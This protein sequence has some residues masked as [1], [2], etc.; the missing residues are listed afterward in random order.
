MFYFENPAHRQKLLELGIL[1]PSEQE[2]TPSELVARMLVSTDFEEVLY[3]IKQDFAQP[4]S[5]YSMLESQLAMTV[6]QANQVESLDD[7]HEC[8]A[9]LQKLLKLPLRIDEITITMQD[10][11]TELRAKIP[12]RISQ[13]TLRHLNDIERFLGQL[14]A[15]TEQNREILSVGLAQL[16]VILGAKQTKLM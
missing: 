3:I 7:L 10:F 15:L 1:V 8:L 4:I 14:S 16:Q 2:L 9:E 11:M 13:E 6:D 5:L 12:I